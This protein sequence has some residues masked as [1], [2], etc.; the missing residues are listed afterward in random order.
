MNTIRNTDCSYN[1]C[2]LSSHGTIQIMKRFNSVI[3]TIYSAKV[4]SWSNYSTPITIATGL[5][6]SNSFGFSILHYSQNNTQNVGHC[7]MSGSNCLVYLT[8][9]TQFDLCHIYQI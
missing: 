9:N 1:L 2:N 4:N 7:K 3:F 6:W 5:P 8:S